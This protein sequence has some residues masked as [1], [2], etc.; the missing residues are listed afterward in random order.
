MF[1]FSVFK[2]EFP[3]VILVIFKINAN[4]IPLISSV[5]FYFS[6]KKRISSKERNEISETVESLFPQTAPTPPSRDKISKLT[7]SLTGDPG[8]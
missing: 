3:L 4:I 6:E 8:R 5:I 2:I 1:S 7:T